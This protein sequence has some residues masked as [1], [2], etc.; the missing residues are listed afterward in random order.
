MAK[1][2][3]K[4]DGIRARYQPEVVLENWRTLMEA[5]VNMNEKELEAALKTEASSPQK[6]R[7]VIERLH[8]KFTRMRQAR[9]LEE[10][11]Q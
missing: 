2:K 10:Y 6:R 1:T 7:D 11:L 9:E 8:R 5:I 4:D 3:E